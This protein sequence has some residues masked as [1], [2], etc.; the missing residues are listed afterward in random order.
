MQRIG[1]LTSGGDSPGMNAGV[2]AAVRMAA[3]RGMEV[4]GFED[5]YRGLLANTHRNLGPRSVSDILDRGGTFL[6]SGRSD[7]FKTAEGVARALAICGEHALEGLV[8]IGGDGS[9]RGAHEL[10]ERGLPTVGVPATIDNDLAGTDYCIGFDTA[11][12]TIISDVSKIRDTASAMDRVF[13]VEVMGRESGQLALHAGLACGAD[14]IAIPEAEFKFDR[15]V[16]DI[17]GGQHSG[18]L[19]FLILVAEGAGNAQDIAARVGEKTGLEVRISVLG[20]IQRGGSPSALDRILASR[21]SAEAV[22]LLMAGERD[23]MV[24]VLGEDIVTVPL[25]EATGSRR[26]I[27]MKM[28]DLVQTLAT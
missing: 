25:P 9:L 13:V 27:D 20:Y 12:N 7:E 10:A 28:Y 26:E 21:L 16:S 6:G 3:V 18:K 19:H 4:V 15:C 17:E 1:I 23:I 5:G 22:E 8:V 24:G 2:R 14:A 11:C